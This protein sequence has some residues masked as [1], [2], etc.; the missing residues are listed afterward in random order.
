MIK[1]DTQQAYDKKNSR[2]ELS[3]NMKGRSLEKELKVYLVPILSIMG[4]IALLAFVSIPAI[5]NVY[6]SFD[7]KELI[8][9]ELEQKNI[10]LRELQELSESNELNSE[11]LDRLD[12]IVPTAQ[13]EVVEFEKKVRNIAFDSVVDITDVII[14]ERVLID[15]DKGVVSDP[16]VPVGQVK[17]QPKLQLVQIPMQF[18]MKGSLP[19]FRDMLLSIYNGNDFIIISEMELENSATEDAHMELV[20]SKYQ[21]LPIDNE[22]DEKLLLSSVSYKQA[23]DEEVIEFIKRK[24]EIDEVTPISEV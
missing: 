1:S 12:R 23:L 21:Y 19:N 8:S 18:D 4:F 3:K 17:R 24:S 20:L 5:K 13:T 22:E 6:A 11:L 2:D 9:S 16:T 7:E 14:G 15:K 10:E